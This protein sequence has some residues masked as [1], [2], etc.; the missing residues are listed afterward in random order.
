MLAGSA[1]AASA[2]AAAVLAGD[3]DEPPELEAW[4][5][6]QAF[7]GDPDDIAEDRQED[8][9]SHSSVEPEDQDIPAALLLEDV[10]PRCSSARASSG[11]CSRQKTRPQSAAPQSAL[12]G[13]Y[14]TGNGDVEGAGSQGSGSRAQSARAGAL[15]AEAKWQRRMGYK[16]PKPRTDELVIHSRTAQARFRFT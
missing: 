13:R 4:K 5:S 15:N 16:P 7:L 3:A 8:I 12:N 10:A 11:P 1:A 2:A 6:V 9:T 14:A